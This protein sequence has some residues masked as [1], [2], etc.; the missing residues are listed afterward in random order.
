MKCNPKIKKT[1]IKICDKGYETEVE[2]RWE[3]VREHKKSMGNTVRTSPKNHWEL[4]ENTLRKK[5]E[6]S[7]GT[8]LEHQHIYIYIY[9]YIYIY[10]YLY[11][12]LIQDLFN[13]VVTK[14]G[15]NKKYMVKLRPIKKTKI[16]RLFL[17]VVFTRRFLTKFWVFWLN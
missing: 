15:R 6:N 5:V 3:Q 4:N 11:I 1:Q 2:C 13:G 16:L 7:K 9:F 14:L 10:I 17:R 8:C 12:N